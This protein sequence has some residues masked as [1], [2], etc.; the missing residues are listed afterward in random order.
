MAKMSSRFLSPFFTILAVFC[1]LTGPGVGANDFRCPE[2]FGYYQH[3]TDCSLYYVCVFGGPLLESCTG[4]LVYSHDLQTCDWPRNV[5]CKTTTSSSSSSINSINSIPDSSGGEAAAE[6]AEDTELPLAI[7]SKKEVQSYSSRQPRKQ[8]HS[9]TKTVSS[10][11]FKRHNSVAAKDQVV[12]EREEEELLSLSPQPSIISTVTHGAT[13]KNLIHPSKERDYGGAK[14]GGGASTERAEVRIS[15]PPQLNF[16]DVLFGS[17]SS[18]KKESGFG[19]KSSVTSSSSSS[20]SRG[21]K[22]VQPINSSRIEQDLLDTYPGVP[23]VLD[24]SLDDDPLDSFYYVKWDDSIYD[25]F[26]DFGQVLTQAEAATEAETEA[27]AGAG[28]AQR[29]SIRV[30]Y[31]DHHPSR[32]QPEEARRTHRGPRVEEPATKC[33]PAKCQLPD[34]MC[35]GTEMPGNLTAS[36]TPQLVVLTF[37]DSVNDLNK[38]LYQDIFHPSRKNPNG[39]PIAATFY[40][41]HEWTDYALVQS[42]YSDG[43][44]IASHSISHSFGEQFSK[45]KWTKEMA[46]QREILAGFAGIKLEDVRGIRAPFL[47]IGGNNMFSMLYEA[48]FTYDSS[49]PIYDNKPPTFP[50]T[51]D[52]KLAH[53]CMIP[54][55]PNKA[56]PGVWELPLVMWNDLKEGRCSMADACSNPPTAEGVYYMIMRNFQRHY[57]TNRAPF[58]LSYHPAWFTTPHHKEGFELFLD[59]IVAMEE[60]WVV[61]A[62]QTVQWMRAP[63]TTDTVHDFKPFQCDYKDRPPR[64]DKPKVCNLWHKSGVRYMR[65][66][67]E[68]PDIYPWTGR[69]GIAN[70]LVDRL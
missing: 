1:L 47:A 59:T 48:N 51:M 45:K 65:T 40:V 17:R 23:K 5:A 21:G 68:C 61:T 25:Q 2:E 64:C 42:L 37:D 62:W 54:P 14:Y 39:C 24:D 6:S 33:D 10:S 13:K 56:Y 20:S 8:S 38:R 57:N 36:R 60:V 30:T 70:S 7:E 46:G 12:S 16:G 69:T 11:S 35:G 43:H 26:D 15:S 31:S 34:C 58:L 63:A 9:S 22:L 27:G 44:E 67:Q 49:M 32:P 3:P 18:S 55:C 53:D 52:Y 19:S 4:G 50:Y 66:C 41:S 28:E 29:S